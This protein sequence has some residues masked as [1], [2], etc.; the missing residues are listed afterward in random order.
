VYQSEFSTETGPIECICN[1]KRGFIKLSYAARDGEFQN[2]YLQTEET[3]KPVDA[4]S[5]KLEI[6]EQE[7][8]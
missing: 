1:Y 7:G 3:R 8:P 4:Q 6:S 5:M 2:S